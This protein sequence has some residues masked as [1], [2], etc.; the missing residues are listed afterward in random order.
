M[1]TSGGNGSEGR[2]NTHVFSLTYHG[3]MNAADILQDMGDGQG[4]SIAGR[5][6]NAVCDDLH[7]E[8]TGNRGAKV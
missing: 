8:T 7:R 4:G 6:R 3:E 1:G 5:G 2:R